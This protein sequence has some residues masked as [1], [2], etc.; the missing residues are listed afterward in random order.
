ML[1]A[2]RFPDSV[3]K[4]AIG[5]DADEPGRAAARKAAEAFTRCGLASRVFF[6]TPPHGDFN[7]E[8]RGGRS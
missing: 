1:P 6:P 2:M 4:V 3:R 5:G 7:D 8:I